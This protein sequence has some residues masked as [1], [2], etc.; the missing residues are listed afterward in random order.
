MA[1]LMLESVIGLLAAWGKYR[2]LRQ[3]RAAN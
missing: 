1:A 3:E 2:H